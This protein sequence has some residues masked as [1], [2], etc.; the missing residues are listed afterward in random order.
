[1]ALSDWDVDV[2]VLESVSAQLVARLKH[3]ASVEVPVDG[4]RPSAV[5]V[6]VEAA[7]S[8]SL[9]ESS[10]VLTRRTDDM[11]TH[12]G[13]VAFAGG[14]VSE[15]DQD[16]WATA[17]REAH[18]EIGLHPDQVTRVMRLDDLVTV[19]GYHMAPMLAV[20][21]PG[22]ELRPDTREVTRIFRL[23]IEILLDDGQ[24]QEETKTW[25]GL[26]MSLPFLRYDGEYIWGATAYVLWTLAGRLRGEPRRETIR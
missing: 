4:L 19:T 8:G 9:E 1:M 12:Q 6:A 18:E 17:T 21:P 5:L 22:V 13:Q 20:V 11:P 3:R 15:V 14:K 2:D 25:K 16:L 7:S 26:S 10:L 23:P 24:W